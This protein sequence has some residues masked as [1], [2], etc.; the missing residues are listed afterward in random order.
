MENSQPKKKTMIEKSLKFQTS[1]EI[2]NFFYEN[3]FACDLW[4]NLCLPS[5]SDHGTDL[6]W[7]NANIHTLSEAC[8]SS[9]HS[10]LFGTPYI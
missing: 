9:A 5:C 10:E 7:I 8:T 3:P 1:L 6:C 2:S 4:D